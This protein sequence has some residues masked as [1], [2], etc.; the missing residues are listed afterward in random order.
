MADD[1]DYSK[2]LKNVSPQNNFVLSNGRVIENLDS[3]YF[4]LRDS[5]DSIFYYHVT[6]ERNDFAN[7][8]KYC[9]FYDALYYKLVN[10]RQKNDFLDV[11]SKELSFLRNPPVVP[12]SLVLPQVQDTAPSLASSPITI[13]SVTDQSTVQSITTQ[14]QPVQVLSQPVP[15][16]SAPVQTTSFQSSPVSSSQI[17]DSTTSTTASSNNVIVES[18][19]EFESIFKNLLEDL[20]KE[21]LS[22]DS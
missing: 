6:N 21:I 10:M 15:I 8:I 20:E 12:S 1:I 16:R 14:Q 17:N 2:Y 5:D 22:W 19:F 4:V 9:I 11:L 3:L 18:V 13:Q 7:W